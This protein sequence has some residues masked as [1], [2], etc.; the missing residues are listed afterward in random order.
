MMDTGCIVYLSISLLRILSYPILS[1]F[2]GIDREGDEEVR[3]RGRSEESRV[4]PVS[5][6][7]EHASIT[8]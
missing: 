8:R 7:R 3:G 6:G 1:Q 4:D 5:F 2:R